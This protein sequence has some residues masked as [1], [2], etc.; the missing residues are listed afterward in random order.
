MTSNTV[1]TSSLR[2]NTC[3]FKQKQQ[4]KTKE[5]DLMTL[6]CKQ[7][8]CGDVHDRCAAD[9]HTE[10]TMSVLRAAWP[11]HQLITFPHM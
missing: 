3:S 8:S 1:Y 7:N 9:A 6:I 2:A 11:D 4:R 10:T 5:K